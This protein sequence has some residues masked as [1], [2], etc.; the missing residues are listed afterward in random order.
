MSDGMSDANAVGRLGA[1]LERA[2]WE[3]RKAI[4]AAQEGHR[5]LAVDVEEEVNEI[6]LPTGWKLVRA[7]KYEAYR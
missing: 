6:L 1:A 4:K 2:T 3:F 5:G 7:E